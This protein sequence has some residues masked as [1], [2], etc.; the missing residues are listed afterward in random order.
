MAASGAAGLAGFLWGGD[1][2]LP[3]LPHCSCHVPRRKVA[4]L[5]RAPQPLP[6][7]LRPAACPQKECGLHSGNVSSNSGGEEQDESNDLW[8]TGNVQALKKDDLGALLDGPREKDTL[9]A[10]YAPWC[11]F[12]K[13]QQ[14]ECGGGW[15]RG[16]CVEQGWEGLWGRLRQS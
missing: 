4:E 1:T 11:R 16:V 12:C 15:R 14:A 6:L 13:V 8:A 9:V 7:L 3:V 10:L 5:P 2:V